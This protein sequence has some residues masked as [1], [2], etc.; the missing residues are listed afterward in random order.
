MK[1]IQQLNTSAIEYKS[2]FQIQLL[3]GQ[4]HLMLTMLLAFNECF[5]NTSTIVS[6]KTSFKPSTYY[7]ELRHMLLEF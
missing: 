2:L 4:I 5:K 6:K 7:I 3:S 1:L